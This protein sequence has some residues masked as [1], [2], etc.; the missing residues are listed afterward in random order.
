MDGGLVLLFLIFSFLMLVLSI[1]LLVKSM[2][3]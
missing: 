2:R 3:L 1:V